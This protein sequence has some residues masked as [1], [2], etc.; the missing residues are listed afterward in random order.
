MSHIHPDGFRRHGRTLAETDFQVGVGNLHHG[1]VMRAN[2]LMDRQELC[3]E[4]MLGVLLDLMDPIINDELLCV[5]P[6]RIA[7]V[8]HIGA[9]LSVIEC[10]TLFLSHMIF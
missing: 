10:K 9:I 1:G 8:K 6:Y 5:A 7:K 3:N 2:A 4:I